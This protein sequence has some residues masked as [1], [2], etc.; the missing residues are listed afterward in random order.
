[1]NVTIKFSTEADSERV[2]RLAEL[3]GKRPPHGDVLLAEVNGRLLAG[4]GMDG[5]VIADPFERTAPVVKLLRTQLS[6][7]PARARRGG[8]WLTRRFSRP[9]AAG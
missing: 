4:I 8:G 2:R 1:M 9:A 3:D 5:T 6:G 7:R